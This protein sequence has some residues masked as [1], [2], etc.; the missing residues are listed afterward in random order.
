MIKHLKTEAFCVAVLVE[1]NGPDDWEETADAERERILTSAHAFSTKAD[2]N[3]Q[4]NDWGLSRVQDMEEKFICGAPP[5]VARYLRS[6]IGI[7]CDGSRAGIDA[8]GRCIHSTTAVQA[9]TLI[10]L[11][12]EKN[13]S[14]LMEAIFDAWTMNMFPGKERF[15]IFGFGEENKYLFDAIKVAWDNPGLSGINVRVAFPESA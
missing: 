5:A 11:I 15:R 10:G 14:R 7:W 8:D 4:L 1:R 13:L 6:Q 3:Q 12:S 9:N 2:L